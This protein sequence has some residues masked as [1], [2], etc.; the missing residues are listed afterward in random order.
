[1]GLIFN[2][3]GGMLTLGGFCLR[4]SGI[5]EMTEIVY[6]TTFLRAGLFVLKALPELMF[7]ARFDFFWPYC[8]PPSATVCYRTHQH[9]DPPMRAVLVR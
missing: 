1:M 6:L 5:M 3:L 9:I 4:G 8:S 7:T 2:R